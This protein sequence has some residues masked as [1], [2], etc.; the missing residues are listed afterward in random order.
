MSAYQRHAIDACVGALLAPACA[1]CGRIVERAGAS[2]CE[3]C[4]SGVRLLT[5]PLCT[6]CGDPLPWVHEP[7]SNASCVRCATHRS[8]I[9]RARALGPYEGALRAIVHS[10]KYRG[11]RSTA[12]RLGALLRQHC[13]DVLDG[14][15]ALVPVPLHYRR[16]WTRGF[17]QADEIARAIGGP[18]WAV[19]RRHRATQT[20]TGL[21]RAA[22]VRNVQGKFV[23]TLRARAM[24][25]V[26]S[27]TLVLVDDVR[28][29]G[30]T[31]DACARVL[32]DGGAA[33]VRAITVARV[34]AGGRR[35]G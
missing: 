9:A 19:L 27:A 20:Q 10:L 4:W 23:L 17:N 15:D 29:T 11:R 28:T 13:S 7:S 31:L 22:R 18:V 5:P 30:A 14:A 12:R 1:A 33:E 8:A 2:I 26:R 35:P 16:R 21:A 24:H 25:R 34:L 32:I 6:R 3:G